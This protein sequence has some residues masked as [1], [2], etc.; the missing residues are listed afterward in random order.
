MPSAIDIFIAYKFIKQL[1]TPWR[2]WDAYK[3][4]LIDEKGG[5][6]KPAETATEKKA[7]PTWKV[8]VRNIKRTLDKLPFGK[9]QLGSFAGALWLLKEEMGVEDITV[10]EEEFTKWL[11]QSP[12]LIESEDNEEKINTVEKGRYQTEDGDII[13]LRNNT[14]SFATVLGEPLFKLTDGLTGFTYM[15]RSSEIGPF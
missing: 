14:E 10:L 13:F 6:I 2:K 1:S 8:L 3:L 7:Y 15:G 5:K 9:T 4:G 12:I 11:E